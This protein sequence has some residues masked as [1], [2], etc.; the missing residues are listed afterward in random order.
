[1]ANAFQTDAFQL[2]AFQVEVAGDALGGTI[3]V[4]LRSFAGAA[5]PGQR[6]RHGDTVTVEAELLAGDRRRHRG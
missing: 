3:S 5:T 4:R 6:S 2:D 1:M